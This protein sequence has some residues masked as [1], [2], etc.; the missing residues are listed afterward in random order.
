MGFDSG[1]YNRAPL[2]EWI[3]LQP[4]CTVV[5]TLGADRNASNSPGK[6]AAAGI[7]M[8]SSQAD[9]PAAPQTATLACRCAAG[10]P[11]AL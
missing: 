5:A 4:S 9:R 6:P 8:P 1:T 11:R 3:A 7:P 10:V 2:P